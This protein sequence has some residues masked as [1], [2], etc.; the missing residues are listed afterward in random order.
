MK[1]SKV[2]RLLALLPKQPLEIYDRVTTVV[3]VNMDRRRTPVRLGNELALPDALRRALGVSSDEIAKLLAES[4]LQ[5]IE[6]QVSLGITIAKGRGP[7]DLA[8]NGNFCLA[9]SIYVLCRLLSPNIVLETGVA[10]GVTSA[11]TL[12]ALAVNRKGTLISVDL[13]PLGRDAD[14]HVG[15][16]VPQ[17]LRERWRL[18]RGPAKRVLPKLLPAIGP[19]DMFVHDSLHTYRHMSFEFAAVWPFLRS[20]GALIADDVESNDAFRDFAAKVRPVFSAV[21][22]EG[23]KNA[24]FGMAVKRA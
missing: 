22:Q 7:F 2:I 20:P 1:L 10:Y 18:H 16:L 11:F 5:R 8:H 19:I 15:A 13:P 9:K 21:V 12:Q 24:L 23:N 6:E 14:R 4:E 17:E 3:D